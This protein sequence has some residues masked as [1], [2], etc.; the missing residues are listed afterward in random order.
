MSAAAVSSYGR[1]VAAEKAGRL[2]DGRQ[3]PVWS[4]FFTPVLQVPAQIIAVGEIFVILWR[5]KGWRSVDVAD[6]GN[7]HAHRPSRPGFCRCLCRAR[8]RRVPSSF[9][10]H[11]LT[12]YLYVLCHCDSDHFSPNNR[13]SCVRV[14][15]RTDVSHARYEIF[16]GGGK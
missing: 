16:R 14:E 13:G 3:L 11:I 1:H 5:R 8:T 15:A 10:A 7:A 6:I 4:K 2:F 12:R 9:M